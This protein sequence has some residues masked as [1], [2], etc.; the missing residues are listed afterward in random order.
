MLKQDAL[1][2]KSGRDNVDAFVQ[3]KMEDFPKS[4]NEFDEEEKELAKQIF[5]N[6]NYTGSKQTSN[7]TK[8]K[9]FIMYVEP[10]KKKRDSEESYY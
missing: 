5:I 10:R 8:K 4:F 7:P 3:K 6:S 2:T 1:N 9:K